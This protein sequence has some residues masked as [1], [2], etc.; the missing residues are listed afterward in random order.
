MPWPLQVQPELESLGDL[1]CIGHRPCPGHCRWTL[2]RDSLVISSALATD[3]A[4]A[5][6]GAF[7]T[8][9]LA[10]CSAVAP[11]HALLQACSKPTPCSGRACPCQGRWKSNPNS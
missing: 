5:A 1:Q 3:H 9:I 7:C 2:I 8:V 11:G 4:L 10:L 6:A